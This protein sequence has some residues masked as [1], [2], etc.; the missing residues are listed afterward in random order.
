MVLL[1][2]S[3]NDCVASC[4][5]PS[6][7]G[8]ISFDYLFYNSQWCRQSFLFVTPF[9]VSFNIQPVVRGCPIINI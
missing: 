1:L 4:N 7:F 5:R 9:N 3:M 8:V 2:V 6:V